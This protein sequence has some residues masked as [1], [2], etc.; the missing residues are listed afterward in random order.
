MSSGSSERNRKVRSTG[1][2]HTFT[3]SSYRNS[4]SAERLLRLGMRR[5]R[6]NGRRRSSPPPEIRKDV[7]LRVREVTDGHNAMRSA[8]G[9]ISSAQ[10][11]IVRSRSVI[12]VSKARNAR[13]SSMRIGY[14]SL[15]KEIAVENEVIEEYVEDG[16]GM[17]SSHRI[18]RKFG[19]VHA[20]MNLSVVHEFTPVSLSGPKLLDVKFSQ[21]GKIWL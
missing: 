15:A 14:S 1:S 11:R 3:K 10:V 2:A 9:R 7:K 21:A 16:N 19:V 17:Y 12:F 6:I 18:M 20:G 13:R 5:E 4:I 8:N